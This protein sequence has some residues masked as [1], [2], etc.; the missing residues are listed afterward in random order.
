[1]PNLSQ[2][3]LAI[4]GRLRIRLTPSEN[5]TLHNL[6]T[7][8]RDFYCFMKITENLDKFMVFFL[9]LLCFLNVSF[10]VIIEVC[11]VEEP[12]DFHQYHFINL[13]TSHQTSTL[14]KRLLLLHENYRKSCQIYCLASCSIS[15]YMSMRLHNVEP[16]DYHQYHLTNLRMS[17]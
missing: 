13:R 14:P 1:M 12:R 17:R 4:S 16:G 8:L 6:K 5:Q 7:F 2:R 3:A 11:V 10:S 9:C 15:F